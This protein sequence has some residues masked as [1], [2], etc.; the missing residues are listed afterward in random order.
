[1]SVSLIGL[2]ANFF[3]ERDFLQKWTITK[4]KKYLPIVFSGLFLV[5][6]LWLPFSEDIFIGLNVLRIKLPLLLLPL[7]IGSSPSLSKKELKTIIIIFFV[8][9]LISTIWVYLVSVDLL[10]TKKSSGTVRDA[11]VFMSHI[12]YSILLSFSIMFLIYLSIK[13]NLNKVLSSVLLIWLVFILFKL[14]TLTAIC[15]LFVAIL[16]CFPFLLKNKKNT[17][18]KQFLTVFVIFIISAVA[19]L[20]YTVNDFY[21]VKNEKRSSKKESIKGEKYLND[22]NDHTTENGYYLWENIAP[23]ELEKEWNKRS[24]INFKGLDHKGQMLKATIYRFLTSKGLDKDSAGLS[25]LSNKEIALIE[26]GE[27]SYIHYNNLEKR[28]RSFLYEIENLKKSKDPNN[29]TTNQRIEF[30]KVGMSIL[31]ENLVFG[32]GPG[33]VKKEYKKYYHKKPTLLAPK[34]QLLAHNQFITQAINLGILGFLM[35]TAILLYS[36]LRSKKEIKMLFFSYSVLMFCAFMSDDMLEVQAG[37]TIFS[38]FGTMMVF[39]KPNSS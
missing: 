15:G 19:Y 17:Y 24:K 34:N 35:W 7:I 21:H 11:S 25:Q 1:M 16:C 23:H 27:T 13:A 12:R 9:L 31:A 29:Q 33:G 14:A 20:I 10:A 6:L 4:Q 22:F 8:G 2:T 38:F 39:Y 36:F 30:W 37:A 32:Y 3:L 28:I 18:N 26:S 5:E